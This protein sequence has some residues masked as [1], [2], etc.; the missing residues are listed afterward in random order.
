MKAIVVFFDSL[1]R[2]YLPAYNP[3]SDTIAPNFARLARHSVQFDNSYVGS[4]PCIPARREL[5]TGRYNFLHREWG[6]LEPF[7]DSMPELLKKNGVYTHLISDHLHYWEDGGATYHTRYSSWE[8][9]R[10]Q[11]GDHWKGEVDPPHIPETVMVP[12]KQTGGGPSGLWRQDWINR[13][14]ITE[15]ADSPQTKCFELG[16]DF[17]RQN[18]DADNWLLHLETFDPHEPFYAPQKY[19]D[20]YDRQYSGKH[21]DWPR[22]QATQSEEEIAHC[23]RQYQALVSMCDHNLGRILDLMD[24]HDLWKDTLLI[25]GT[26]H[27]F[28]LAEHAYWGKNQMP[29]YNEVA[30]TPLYIWDP[31]H[32]VRGESRRSL[33]QLIDWAPTL[34]QYFNLPV[35]K[36]MEGKNLEPVIERDAPLRSHA[37]Y[38]V[39]SG[40]VNVTDGRY[41]YM[42]AALPEKK[43]DIYN[44]TLIPLHMNERF[45]A[46]EL[47]TARLYPPF[48]FTKACPVLKIKSK[49]KYAV[50]QFGTLLFDLEADPEQTRPIHNPEVETRMISAML[51]LMA[52]NG[53]PPEQYERLGLTEYLEG[54][55]RQA[56]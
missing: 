41:A 9:V 12:Q 24:R 40:H 44:Y 54:A 15:E 45:S 48:S 17:I 55:K 10:G 11:E 51:E 50:Q 56:T 2:R 34:L 25:I 53:C 36:D 39:F 14:Y 38:G 31:R 52:R 20:L 42:R 47:Q 46:R 37:L 19:L 7:D 30:H 5:H 35:P 4:M 18:K 27:G 22:G 33:V 29:Y 13:K 32:G 21:F 49:E 28:L 3:E 8:L 16:C 23:R 6:P 1:N 26:D 43:D